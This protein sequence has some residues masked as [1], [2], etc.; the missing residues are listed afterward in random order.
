MLDIDSYIKQIPVINPDKEYWFVRTNSGELYDIFKDNGF[1]AI[2]WN[3]ITIEDIVNSRTNPE[4][5]RNKIVANSRAIEQKRADDNGVDID[6]SKILQPS[7]RK[8]KSKITTV[9]NKL[10]TFHELK[11]GDIIVIP[12]K[13]SSKLCFGVV[14]DA[15]IDLKSNGENNCSYFKRRKINWVTE[16]SFYEIGTAFFMFKKNMHSISSVKKELSSLIDKVMNDIYYKDDKLYYKVK[17]DKINDI[18][19]S[20]LF[21]LGAE[22]LELLEYINKEFEFGENINDTIVKINVQSKGDFLF[23]SNNLGKSIAVLSLVLSL[24]SCGSDT[25][26]IIKDRHEQSRIEK[27]HKKMINLQSTVHR[28]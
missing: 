23:N 5:L 15:E 9:I 4:I 7:K 12:N 19:A 10:Q 18:K 21:V 2:G 11:K 20:D 8:D 25:S 6:E 17:V 13:G 22:M 14:A 1:I 3:Y 16:K 27:I 28:Y 26:H 24:V